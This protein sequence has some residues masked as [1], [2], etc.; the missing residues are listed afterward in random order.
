MIEICDLWGVNLRLKVQMR[1]AEVV[2]TQLYGCVTWSPNKA[3]DDRL[4]KAHQPLLILC[5]VWRKKKREDHT[6]SYA[7]TR[8]KTDSEAFG[9]RCGD[10]G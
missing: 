2:D 1:K 6:L 10:G 5:L 8:V 4:R 7:D 3:D 9:R